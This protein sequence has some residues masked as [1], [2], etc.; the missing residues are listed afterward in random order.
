M[1]WHACTVSA[2]PAAVASSRRDAFREFSIPTLR[3][4]PFVGNST[5]ELQDDL[6]KSLVGMVCKLCTSLGSL[7]RYV[8]RLE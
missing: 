7:K 5:V 8:E 4:V 1:P 6:E 3:S 2:S